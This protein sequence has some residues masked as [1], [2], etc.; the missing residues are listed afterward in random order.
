M[1]TDLNSTLEVSTESDLVCT[2]SCSAL[3]AKANC[4][5]DEDFPQSISAPELPKRHK[6]KPEVP[7]EPVLAQVDQK[8]PESTLKEPTKPALPQPDQGEPVSQELPLE[9]HV[10]SQGVALEPVSPLEDLVKSHPIQKQQLTSCGDLEDRD[11]PRPHVRDQLEPIKR[12]SSLGT[13]T[14]PV[15]MESSQQS[16]EEAVQ[17]PEEGELSESNDNRVEPVQPES[18]ERDLEEQIKIESPQQHHGKNTNL[19]TAHK[20]QDKQQLSQQDLNEQVE[21]AKGL[22]GV[23]ELTENKR[24]ENEVIS[25]N[26]D[27]IKLEKTAHA[28]SEQSEDDTPQHSETS[29]A[30]SVLATEQLSSSNHLTVDASDEAGTAAVQS[31]VSDHSTLRSAIE[32]NCVSWSSTASQDDG[33]QPLG[34]RSPLKE[35][36]EIKDELVD[37]S[38]QLLSD[39]SALP[40]SENGEPHPSL[41]EPHLPLSDSYSSLKSPLSALEENSLLIVPE[42]STPTPSAATPLKT[43]YLLATDCSSIVDEHHSNP[44]RLDARSL[45]TST[46]AEASSSSD[47]RMTSD[48]KYTEL[49]PQ[50]PPWSPGAEEL[51]NDIKDLL[52][53][54]QAPLTADQLVRVPSISRN[55]RYYRVSVKGSTPRSGRRGSENE[56]KRSKGSVVS[57]FVLSILWLMMSQLSCATEG[58]RELQ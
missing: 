44:M 58:G 26:D 45:K 11:S 39:P 47:R 24:G 52:T 25:S 27:V 20:D 57:H 8:R 23:E 56:E 41:S 30:I 31:K 40:T 29:V 32:R 37:T 19:E 36:R 13:E 35:A 33:S 46:Q 7:Q 55:N 2:Q 16:Q 6:V 12:E 18:S 17:D 4:E 1:M 9:E 53:V 51:A 50:E 5:Y 38:Q 48:R 43:E 15:L 28:N 21:R 10:K 54:V 22:E 42:P 14:E 34:E 3:P 49:I